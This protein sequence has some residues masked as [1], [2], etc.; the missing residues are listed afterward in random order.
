MILFLSLP[1]L[2]H[3]AGTLNGI[4][5]IFPGPDI[6]TNFGLV[7]TDGDT[8]RWIC[9]EAI[10]AEGAIISPRYARSSEGVYLGTVPAIEQAREPDE[11]VYRSADGCSWDPV[12]GLTGEHVT[13]LAFAPDDPQIAL[14]TSANLGDGRESGLFRSTDG[15]LSFTAVLS[16]PGRLFRSL[17]FSPSLPGQVWATAVWYDT[18]EAWVYYSD[19][20]GLTWAEHESPN[21]N[22]LALFDA[23]VFAVS[24][25]DPATAWIN[26]GPYGGDTLF[27]TTDGGERFTA[28]MEDVSGDLI[29]GVS[30]VD[31][32]VWLAASG[33][34]LFYAPD[35][36]TFDAVT[37]PPGGIGIGANDEAVYPTSVALITAI[38]Y[39][40]TD[41]GGQTFTDYVYLT[42]LQSPPQCPEDSEVARICDPLWPELEGRLPYPLPEDTAEDTD[43]PE[44]SGIEDEDG[45]GCQ[46]TDSGAAVVIGLGLGLL[47]WR[48]RR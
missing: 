16:A 4:D 44:D 13:R 37:S 47:G 7:V 3:V 1:A 48:R 46:G 24:P 22:N 2:A 14:A 32:G 12:K 6:E 18:G 25:D 33:S 27:R 28:V 17:R 8:H 9:H 5:M 21:P 11:G 38:L 43:T 26:V 35:G 41:D 29:D 23:D 42:D 31:G 36:E 15:G 10:T 30:D 20:G 34:R 40:R 19:D 39:A 45:C